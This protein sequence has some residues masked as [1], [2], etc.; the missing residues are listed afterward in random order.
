[1][2][3]IDDVLRDVAELPDRNSP[4]DQPEM[5]L[6]TA[7][8]LKAILEGFSL[9]QPMDNA[10]TESGATVI[11]HV[12]SF[13][14]GESGQ[15]GEAFLWD[16]GLWYWAG[17]TAGYHDPVCEGNMPPTSWMPMPEAPNN[18]LSDPCKK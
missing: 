9:W 2:N 10:P 5:M 1:M 17:S 6:V 15:V 8:E 4:P 13:N 12:P 18:R 3:W 16:D 14:D 7:D 11:L